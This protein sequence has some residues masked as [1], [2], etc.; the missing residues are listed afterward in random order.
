MEGEGSPPG[1]PCQNH[2][3]FF[4]HRQRQTPK[5]VPIIPAHTPPPAPRSHPAAAAVAAAACRPVVVR[6][7]APLLMRSPLWCADFLFVC[8]HKWSEKV[9][10]AHYPHVFA[11]SVMMAFVIMINI[12]S[13]MSVAGSLF[14][15]QPPGQHIRRAYAVAAA[16]AMLAIVYAYYSTGG[17][18][19]KVINAF[20]SSGSLGS[21]P[22]LVAIGAV[23]SSL[24]IL[25]AIW[26]FL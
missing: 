11:A 8:F 15:L 21:R 26:A 17:R 18:L 7:H 24:T 23:I 6:R 25:F 16:I 14:E 10:G 2:P 1:E 12:A 5:N 19:S 9:N 4:R 22:G 13:F 3:E 20:D